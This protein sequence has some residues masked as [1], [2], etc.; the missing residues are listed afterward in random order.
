M[1]LEHKCV[2]IHESNQSNLT[3]R[4]LAPSNRAPE[5]IAQKT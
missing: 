4:Q 2:T 1:L 3:K 5:T